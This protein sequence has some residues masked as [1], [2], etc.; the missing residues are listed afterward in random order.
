[1]D[2][3]QTLEASEDDISITELRVWDE[4][5]AWCAVVMTPVIWWLQG[6][7]VSTDQFVVRTGL[8]VIS[9]LTGVG[10]R[11]WAIIQ[12]CSLSERDAKVM[13]QPAAHT[14]LTSEGSGPTANENQP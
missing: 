13:E 6:P 11:I 5:G 9:L 1:M 2:N 8:I 10:L 12:P 14:L 4:F 3:N 7:S